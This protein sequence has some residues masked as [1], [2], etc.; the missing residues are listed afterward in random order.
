M[1]LSGYR[2]ESRIDLAEDVV[3]IHGSWRGGG[4]SSGKIV[5]CIC[6]SAENGPRAG[7]IVSTMPAYTW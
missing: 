7:L 5:S 3:D 2:V 4:E 6:A 1:S